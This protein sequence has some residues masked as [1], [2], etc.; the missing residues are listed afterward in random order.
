VPTCEVFAWF[1]ET[2]ERSSRKPAARV[3]INGQRV[4]EIAAEPTSGGAKKHDSVGI[5]RTAGNRASMHPR[6]ADRVVAIPHCARCAGEHRVSFAVGEGEVQ[7]GLSCLEI[8][9]SWS[10][11]NQPPSRCPSSQPKSQHAL[12]KAD[13]ASRSAEAPHLGAFLI[14][15]V[16]VHARS[17]ENGRGR[18]SPQGTRGAYST[19]AYPL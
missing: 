16:R 6:R 8:R 15:P 17:P 12:Q 1:A 3:S 13:A 9:Y 10:G 2:L 7:A 4:K 19:A 14:Q 18:A 11:N 5:T